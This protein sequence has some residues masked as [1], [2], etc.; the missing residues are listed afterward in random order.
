MTGFNSKRQAARDKMDD[1]SDT[2]LLVYQ[3]GFANGKKAAQ[4]KPLTNEEISDLWCKVSNTDFVTADTHVFARAIEA[5]HN[6]K[7]QP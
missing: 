3:H 2:L 4:R 5:A 7:E 6:I 1:D